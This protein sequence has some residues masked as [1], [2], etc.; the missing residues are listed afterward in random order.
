MPVQAAANQGIEKHTKNFF[1][2]SVNEKNK[3]IWG[4]QPSLWQDLKKISGLQHI[5]LFV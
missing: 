5:K 2:R 4:K 3:N 1:S